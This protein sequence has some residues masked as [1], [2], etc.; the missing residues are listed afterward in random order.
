MTN[1]EVIREKNY[2]TVVLREKLRKY[3]PYHQV[4]LINMNLLLVK[5]YYFLIKVKWAKFAYS[6]Q[7]KAFKKRT[8]TTEDQGEKRTEAFESLNFFNKI[9]ASSWRYIFR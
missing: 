7:G 4:K 3:H 2:N 9:N 8:K 5:K 6:P 1:D